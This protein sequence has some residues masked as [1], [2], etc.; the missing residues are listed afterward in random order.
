MVYELTIQSV[1]PGLCDLT[2]RLAEAIAGCGMQD[3]ICLVRADRSGVGV[4]QAPCAAEAGQDIQDDFARLFPNAASAA[5]LG[6]QMLVLT[7]GE[8]RLRLPAAAAVFAAVRDPQD[9]I[10]IQVICLS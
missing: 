5:A 10:Q 1:A 2:P 3:G 9:A 8:G 4:F 7:V 6:S